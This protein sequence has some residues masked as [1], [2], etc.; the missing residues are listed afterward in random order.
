M[1][2][3]ALGDHLLQNCLH[4][5]TFSNKLINCQKTGLL[6]LLKIFLFSFFTHFDIFLPFIQTL[7][8]NLL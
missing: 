6:E 7:L 5:V 3:F 8:S 2:N 4:V 1:S